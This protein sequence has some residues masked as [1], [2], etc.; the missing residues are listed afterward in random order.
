MKI[1][2]AI[3]FVIA[4]VSSYLY[5]SSF[6]VY[7]DHNSEIPKTLNFVQDYYVPSTTNATNTS[8]FKSEVTK[9]NTLKK[10]GKHNFI[11]E[12]WFSPDLFITTNA[13]FNESDKYFNEPL[14]SFN[15]SRGTDEVLIGYI[16]PY[17]IYEEQTNGANNQG[18]YNYGLIK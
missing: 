12:I 13:S 4:C 1:V 2:I 16:L 18:N 10:T 17:S 8:E 7:Y 5:Q 6:S 11:N 14:E 15:E 9:T 3:L